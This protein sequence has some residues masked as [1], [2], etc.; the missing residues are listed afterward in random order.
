[1]SKSVFCLENWPKW[2]NSHLLNP[3]VLS[4]CWMIPPFQEKINLSQKDPRFQVA[5]RTPPSLPKLSAP[6][7]IAKSLQILNWESAVSLILQLPEFQSR[8]KIL[9]W[10]L[11]SWRWDWVFFELTWATSTLHV[12]IPI[13][14]ISFFKDAWSYFSKFSSLFHWKN[15][16]SKDVNFK[17]LNN[18]CIL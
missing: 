6:L 12:L 16:H 8:I 17:I 13:H 14:I 5:I 11:K 18:I 7:L 10:I 3:R 4:S 15:H 1:M 2:T 9:C